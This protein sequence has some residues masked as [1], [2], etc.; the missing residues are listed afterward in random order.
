M[1]K[2]G[3][4]C[5]YNPLHNGHVYHYEK[6]K[7]LSNADYVIL[8]LS[9]TLTQRGELA[10]LD[11]F[12]RTNLALEMGVDLVLEC[13]SLLSMNEAAI[14]AKAHIKNLY[15]AG[16]DEIWIGAE[17]GN[18][19]MYEEYHKI[20]NTPSFKKKINEFLEEGISYKESFNKAFSFLNYSPL[21]SNDMLG[22]F[23]YDAIKEI[24]PNVKLMTIKRTNS[25]TE[26]TLNQTNIQSAS[27]IRNNLD[28]S[29]YYVPSYTKKYLNEVLDENKLVPFIKYN[30]I[31]HSLK[32]LAESS[33]GLENRLE[34]SFGNTFKE[35]VDNIKTKRYSESKIRRLL[36]DTC[37]LI[38]KEDV[39][40]A[41][42][43]MNYLRVLGFNKNGQKLINEIKTKTDVYMNIKNGI[44]ATLDFELKISKTLDIIYGTNLLKQEITK[45]II[46]K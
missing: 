46:K 1:K 43:S 24:C 5:E 17:D 25:Y 15:L 6:V 26:N 32:S 22:Y 28:A 31:N 3:L 27:A 19:N 13:P 34:K 40:K 42:N 23:Y 21:K 8:S 30:I 33:E 41:I 12:I 2:I 35:L 20:I 10:I 45:P 39:N 18:S 29:S 36:M 38:T 9:S 37:F 14:F 7:E 16:V 44:N 4:I 11:K